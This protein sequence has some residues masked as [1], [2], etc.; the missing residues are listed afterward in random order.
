MKKIAG[1]IVLHMSTKNQNNGVVPEIQSETDRIF[2]HFGP[3]LALL[4]PPPPNN[5]KNQ[6]FEKNEK[7]IWIYHY[8]THVYQKR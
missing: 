7:S 3:F 2:C 4:P 6:N 1:D 5:P 8:F